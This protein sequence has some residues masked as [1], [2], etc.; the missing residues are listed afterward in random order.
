MSVRCL[1]FYIFYLRGVFCAV[2]T[3]WGSSKVLDFGGLFV[4]VALRYGGVLRFGGK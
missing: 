1:I 3:I 4:F 2:R